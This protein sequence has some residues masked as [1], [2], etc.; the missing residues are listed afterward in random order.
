M[1]PF[2]PNDRQ[3]RVRVAKHQHGI[4]LCLNH[5]FVRGVDD[6]AHRRSQ[7]VAHGIHI[8]FRIFQ[9]QVFEE[10]AIEVVIVVLTSMC[11]DDIEILTRFVDDCC[12]T[13]DL[14]PCAD[15]NQ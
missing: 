5:E 12:K 9:L 14:G 7:V 13:Y 10:N 4:R 6:I 1:Q 15:N 11:E 2:G 8:H 3:A